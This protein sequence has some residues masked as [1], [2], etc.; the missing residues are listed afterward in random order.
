MT[1]RI[2]V[3]IPAAGVG[4]RMGGEV[5]KQYLPLLGKTVLEQTLTLFCHAP[6]I[7]GVVVVVAVTDRWWPTLDFHHPK[8][9]IAIGGA[10]RSDSVLNGLKALA[11]RIEPSAD[12]TDWVLVHD[13]ARPCLAMSDLERLLREVRGDSVGGLLAVAVHD[14]LKR[15]DCR[16]RVESTPSREGIWRALTPQMFRL[17]LLQRALAAAVADGVAITDEASAVERLGLKPL[18]VAAEEENL[19]IT[20]PA[21]LL[22]AEAV[23][24]QRGGG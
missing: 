7:D 20:W 9:Q 24:R 21:D 14:T 23:L 5:P 13:A 16:G 8:L 22:R 2:W 19:K 1:E 6:S 10:E 18:V 4:R 3:V 12:P 17:E 15:V 11:N